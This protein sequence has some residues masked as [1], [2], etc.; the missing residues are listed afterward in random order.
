MVLFGVVSVALAAMAAFAMAAGSSSPAPNLR[1]WGMGTDSTV[2]PGAVADDMHRLVVYTRT[3]RVAFVDVGAAG[4]SP[5]DSFMF[6]DRVRNRARTMVIGRD[7]V[8]CT[9]RIRSVA[10][11]GTIF[12]A[13]RGTITI[14]GATYGPNVFAITGGTGEFARAAGELHVTDV[15]DTTSRLVFLLAD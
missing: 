3:L 6:E 12:L 2:R 14:G 11:D 5:G 8:A 9:F 13:G 10:C 15:S 7:S 4:E 1:A